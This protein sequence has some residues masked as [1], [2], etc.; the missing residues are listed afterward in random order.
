VTSILV[1]LAA[2]V[3][4]LVVQAR[5]GGTAEVTMILD[6]NE[7]SWPY[8]D[9]VRQAAVG[10][11]ENDAEARRIADELAGTDAAIDGVLLSGQSHFSFTVRAANIDD[12]KAA[13]D[14][15]AVWVADVNVADQA[16]AYNDDLAVLTDKQAQVH[17]DIDAFLVPGANPE[18]GTLESGRY[19]QNISLLAEYERVS[20]EL[21]TDVDLIR[22]Q[23]RAIGPARA[24][25][26]RI[27]PWVTG[28]AAVVAAL[29]VFNLLDGPRPEPD[30]APAQETEEQAPAPP[31]DSSPNDSD[32]DADQP[33]AS[34]PQVAI[35]KTEETVATKGAVKKAAVKI[36]V[37]KKPVPKKPVPKKPVA[38]KPGVPKRPA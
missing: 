34:D 32:P 25:A 28:F 8:H 15:L 1:G 20:A 18:D 2:L 23:I 7:V 11:L 24:P 26:S 37:P 35:V 21:Q 14:A 17:V 38:P 6:Q 13:T 33:S 5:S 19:L 27:A 12:A 10:H 29:A 31:R 30:P 3:L 16:V 36:A 4:G 9:A 22:P